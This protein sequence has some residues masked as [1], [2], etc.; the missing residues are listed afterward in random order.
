VRRRSRATWNAAQ[1][2]KYRRLLLAWY[3]RHR[4][5]LPWRGRPTP[6]RVWIAEIMLQQTR[7]ATV[8]PYYERFLQRFPDIK[9]L[10]AASE[11]DVLELWAGLGYYRRARNLLAAAVIIAGRHQGRFPETLEEIRELPGVG[12]YTAGAIHSIAFNQPQ[13]AVDGNVRRVIGRLHGLE[14]AP[15]QFCWEQAELLLD[16]RSPA[17]FNQALMELGA[18]TCLPARPS[19]EVCP[20]RGF[21]RFPLR[22]P[23]AVSRK[24]KSE[25][26][27]AVDLVVL[28]LHCNG[29]FVLARN[30][31]LSYVPGAWGLPVQT[32][33]A[34]RQPHAEAKRL[35]V[36]ILGR[37]PR[38]GARPVVRHAITDRR[39]RAHVFRTDLPPPQPALPSGGE[40]AWF[41][42]A[43]LRRL[44]TSSLYR[45][46]LEWGSDPNPS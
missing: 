44:L 33:T 8:L 19:C 28:V 3:R 41:P 23:V 4:R 13:P 6:Y 15:E 39:I 9:T 42:A 29:Q 10:A 7:V 38:L 36:R 25:A 12:R 31:E 16:R 27:H 43:S 5:R 20:V 11:D 32:L 26:F 17:D 21:C 22:G 14:D 46:C 18:L 30:A 2:R 40:Y 24:H 34:A 35:A 37:A 45:K 1:I